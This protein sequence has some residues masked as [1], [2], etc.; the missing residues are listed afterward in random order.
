MSDFPQHVNNSGKVKVKVKVRSLVVAADTNITVLGKLTWSFF[1]QKT[2]TLHQGDNGKSATVRGGLV[3]NFHPSF[4]P[5]DWVTHN[6]SWLIFWTRMASQGL[7]YWENHQWETTCYC[8]TTSNDD[9]MNCACCRYV[10]REEHQRVTPVHPCLE[11]SLLE[12]KLND[13]A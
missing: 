1:D 12:K 6:H 8:Q 5:P 2:V 11:N 4:G 9:V 3:Q 13:L 7:S 10:Q